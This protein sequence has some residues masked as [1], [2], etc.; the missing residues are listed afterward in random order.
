MALFKVLRGQEANLASQPLN[1]G[2]AYFCSDTGNFFIDHTNT[3]G[4]LV[5]SQINADAAYALRY[6]KDGSEVVVLA[7]EVVTKS[8]LDSTFENYA[9]KLDK[10]VSVSFDSV[11]K[12]LVFTT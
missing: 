10:K 1:D 8:L 2:W 12:M 4:S 3:A 11:Q 5:R 7:D 9:S 6:S